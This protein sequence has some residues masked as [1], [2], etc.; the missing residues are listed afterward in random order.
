MT[1]L[2]G[3][4]QLLLLALC[5]TAIGVFCYIIGTRAGYDQCLDELTE[6]LARRDG[7]A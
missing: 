5:F 2:N 1:V 7:D 6:E 3:P 4:T